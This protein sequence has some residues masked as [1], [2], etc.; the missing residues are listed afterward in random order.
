MQ[1]A[2]DDLTADV[3]YQI[4]ALQGLARAAGTS[5]R[6]VKPHGALYNAIAHDLAQADAVI[7]AIRAVDPTLALMAL[8]G[9]PLVAMRARQG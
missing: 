2:P 8:A 6:Y 4:G 1:I 5:V 9:S 3:I 7:A